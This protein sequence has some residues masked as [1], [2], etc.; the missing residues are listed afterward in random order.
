MSYSVDQEICTGCGTCVE[1]CPIEA[2]EC[3]GGVAT[4]DDYLCIMCGA[5]QQQCPQNAVMY[6]G[7]HQEPWAP[8][9]SPGQP[10][11]LGDGERPAT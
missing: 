7:R 9:P 2:V 11:P 4:I 6:D 10:N 5:C 3:D 8:L 1:A